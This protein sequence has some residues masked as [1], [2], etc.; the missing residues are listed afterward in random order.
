[1]CRRPLLRRGQR[2][3]REAGPEA[4]AD[5]FMTFKKLPKEKLNIPAA[6]KATV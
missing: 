4:Y 2:K 1:L 3:G 5:W 6:A